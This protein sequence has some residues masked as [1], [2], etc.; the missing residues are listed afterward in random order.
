MYV[1]INAQDPNEARLTVLRTCQD[2][3]APPPP[4]LRPRCLSREEAGLELDV[5]SREPQRSY[6]C[7]MQDWMCSSTAWMERHALVAQEHG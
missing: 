4:A 5:A 2:A 6:R 7:V 1:G 3:H